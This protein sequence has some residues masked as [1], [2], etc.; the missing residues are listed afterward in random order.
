[1]FGEISNSDICWMEPRD[2]MFDRMN[3]RVNDR[4]NVGLGSPYGGARIALLDGS[5]REVKDTW[6]P[7]TLRALP[8]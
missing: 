3:F 5:V 4:K 6:R 1:M 8:N 7:E 2:L